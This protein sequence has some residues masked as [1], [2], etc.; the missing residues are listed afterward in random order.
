[1]NAASDNFRAHAPDYSQAA[2]YGRAWHQAAWPHGSVGSGAFRLLTPSSRP[3]IRYL[4]RLGIPLST[5]ALQI[6][7]PGYWRSRMGLRYFCIAASP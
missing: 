6:R 5:S 3:P 7:C 1:M 4:A 2:P